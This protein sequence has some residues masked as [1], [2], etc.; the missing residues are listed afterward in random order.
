MLEMHSGMVSA[1]M[2]LVRHR[3][4]F[5]DFA[6]S[7]LPLQYPFL[8]CPLASCSSML[9]GVGKAA[10]RETEGAVHVRTF[11]VPPTIR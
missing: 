3:G 11:L 6:V 5:R 9:G 2:P 10:T 7:K 8:P 4:F 1:D